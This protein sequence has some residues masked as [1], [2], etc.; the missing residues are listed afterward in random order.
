MKESHMQKLT[1]S[2]I[3]EHFKQQIKLQLP[4]YFIQLSII[5]FVKKLHTFNHNFLQRWQQPHE[6]LMLTTLTLD[7][8][9]LLLFCCE[10]EYKCYQVGERESCLLLFL[11]QQGQ[12]QAGPSSQGWGLH[13][14]Q[15]PGTMWWCIQC[16]CGIFQLRSHSITVTPP[17]Y[18]KLSLWDS[19]DK[20]LQLFQYFLAF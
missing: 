6:P 12:V 15:E 2:H 3:T 8:D 13:Y 5:L 1:V 14:T 10:N 20:M 16:S 19:W 4:E 11:Y 7:H 17:V 18:K 9:V